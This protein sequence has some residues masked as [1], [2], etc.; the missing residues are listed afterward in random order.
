LANGEA[1]PGAERGSEG[2]VA[3]QKKVQGEKGK[4]RIEAR[5]N[6]W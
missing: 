1:K 5:T 6:L 3:E 4:T 2:V